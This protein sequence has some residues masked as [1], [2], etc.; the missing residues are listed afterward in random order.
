MPLELI[1]RSILAIFLSTHASLN[2]SDFKVRGITIFDGIKD[3]LL[4]FTK[5]SFKIL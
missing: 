4:F 3:A 2:I 5:I 1:S